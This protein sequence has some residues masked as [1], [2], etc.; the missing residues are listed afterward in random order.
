[1]TRMPAVCI[2][3]AA[4]L[5]L[6]APAEA[7]L[8]R[9]WDS[10]FGSETPELAPTGGFADFQTESRRVEDSFACVR[11][12]ERAGDEFSD[13]RRHCIIGEHRKV[14]V[15]IY[16]PGGHEGLTKKVKLTWIDNQRP[17]ARNRDAPKHADR[18][19][20]RASVRRLAEL[21]LPD[22]LDRMMELFSASRNGVVSEG[23]F[24]A[25]LDFRNR[26]DFVEATIEV[27][28]GNYQAL[29]RA[30]AE[31]GRPGYD[32][33][34]YILDNIPPLKGQT[35]SGDA[36]P[37]RSDLFVSYFLR[38]GRGEKFICELHESG[39]YRIRV[40]QKQGEPFKTLAHGNLGG[41]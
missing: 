41:D 31:R 26:S 2:T 38:S 4:A 7:Q 28:D 36:V 12:V 9:V 13:R 3:F 5:A 20:A 1:M 32:K 8:G 10:L 37:Q 18:A 23:L 25:V 16:E 30:E 11:F 6:A 40:S 14:R 39:Y 34:L 33:C 24:I 35:F 17:N 27:R 21:Y 29:A 19:E 15:T 22:H